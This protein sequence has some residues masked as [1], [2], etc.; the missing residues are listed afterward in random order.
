[1]GFQPLIL[2]HQR[3]IGGHYAANGIG[4]MGYKLVV[5]QWAKFTHRISRLCK[6][7]YN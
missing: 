1:M 3:V 6:L 5:T 4:M 2:G 7:S